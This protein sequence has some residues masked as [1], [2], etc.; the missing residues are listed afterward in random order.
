MIKNKT[1]KFELVGN[2]QLEFVVILLTRI[3][4]P[5][6]Q[7]QNRLLPIARGEKATWLYPFR[8]WGRGTSWTELTR[9][10]LKQF[11]G[12]KNYYEYC[13]S[14]TQDLPTWFRTY[15]SR[16]SADILLLDV[17]VLIVSARW[18]EVPKLILDCWKIQNEANRRG[19]Q[20]V[21]FT[22][23][24]A[25]PGD[26]LIA[27][28]LTSGKHVVVASGLL[29]KSKDFRRFQRIVSPAPLVAVYNAPKSESP[30]AH[31]QRL[32]DVFF[33]GSLYEPR[34]SFFEAL[35]SELSA[36]SVNFV[37]KKGKGDLSLGQYFKT[38][39][40]SKIVVNTSV[41]SE[42][43]SVKQMTGKSS[44]ASSCGA[45]L[46]AERCEALDAFLRP[47]EEY[48]PFEGL[49][50]PAGVAELITQFLADRQSREAIALAGWQRTQAYLA[51]GLFWP[52]V[53]THLKNCRTQSSV[54]G[55]A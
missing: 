23:D 34:K 38:L 31:D 53:A 17:R 44:E 33:G 21:V 29:P 32:I 27:F 13:L 26:R 4:A 51:N 15:V 6:L 24:W 40:S 1:R 50:D 49:D 3:A 41:F 20:I 7:S 11:V 52:S 25:G 19:M 48:V 45:L 47:G 46:I 5:F 9:S 54:K 36:K 28:A 39:S 22:P 55:T 42:N 8:E 16:S 14:A 18:F 30:L 12:A 10:T 2:P 35:A 43:S 37:F